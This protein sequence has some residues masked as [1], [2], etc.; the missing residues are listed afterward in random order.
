M[1]DI[2]TAV[3]AWQ[4]DAPEIGEVHFVQDDGNICFVYLFSREGWR[5]L[6]VRE[7]AMR[8][9]RTLQPFSHGTDVKVFVVP[10]SSYRTRQ[11]RER[12]KIA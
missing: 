9:E 3:K 8:L 10:V 1:E 12:L 11:A 7:Q 6:E 4:Q 2:K 5:D